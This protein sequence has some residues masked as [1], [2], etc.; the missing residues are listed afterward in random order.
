M[1]KSTRPIPKI[2]A[3]ESRREMSSSEELLGTTKYDLW[4]KSLYE[5]H[6]PNAVIRLA[7]SSLISAE[8]ISVGNSM[9][10]DR[11]PSRTAI[12]SGVPHLSLNRQPP[13]QMAL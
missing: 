12:T 9:I 5:Q 2:R 7:T 13:R 1:S 10:S 3:S 4:E 11:L 8:I 6:C